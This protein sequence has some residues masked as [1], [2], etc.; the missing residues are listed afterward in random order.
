MFDQA[1]ERLND[2]EAMLFHMRNPRHFHDFRA[3]FLAFLTFARS[4]LQTVGKAGKNC[5]D[6]EEFSAWFNGALKVEIDTGGTLLN[7]LRRTRDAGI[8]ESFPVVEPVGVHV[9]S[10]HIAETTPEKRFAVGS[11]IVWVENK[12]TH[13]ERRRPIENVHATWYVSLLSHSEVE[14]PQ[15]HFGEPLSSADLIHLCQQTQEAIEEL[16]FEARRLFGDPPPESTD[17]AE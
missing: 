11:S 4:V 12:G 13:R 5:P 8:H 14:M 15:Q 1:V 10:A 6:K 7:W 2:M 17:N 3:S 16:A 9:H